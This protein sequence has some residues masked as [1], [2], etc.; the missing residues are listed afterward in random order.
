MA[1]SIENSSNGAIKTSCTQL[2][3]RNVACVGTPGSVG[4][5]LLLHLYVYYIAYHMVFPS[6]LLIRCIVCL[7]E[8]YVTIPS[9]VYFLR[10]ATVLS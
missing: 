3:R 7:A 5:S 6:S 9:S 8:R 10:F 4:F 1:T 2:P